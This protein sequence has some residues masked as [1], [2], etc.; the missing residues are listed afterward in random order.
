MSEST[1]NPNDPAFLASRSLDETLDDA[2]QERLRDVRSADASV[3]T[4]ARQLAAVDALVRKWSE[5]D[6]YGT[7][8]AFVES[9]LGRIV[10]EHDEKNHALDQRIRDWAGNVPQVDARAFVNGVR[11]RMERGHGQRRRRPM[12][13][14]LGVPLAAA[15]SIALALSAGLWFRSARRPLVEVSIGRMALGHKGHASD[16]GG[17]SGVVVFD[18]TIV[19]GRTK[20]RNSVG[21]AFAMIGADPVPLGSQEVPPL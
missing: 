8:D 1:Y 12:L 13:F 17:A 7:P 10:D 2:D 14:R 11:R 4:E 20:E 19:A 9:V 6:A 15:A 18:R 21:V 3:E 5:S 16:L